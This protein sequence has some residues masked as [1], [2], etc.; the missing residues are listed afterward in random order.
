MLR[1]YGTSEAFVHPT[2]KLT[3]FQ[4]LHPSLI[5]NRRTIVS[6]SIWAF[7]TVGFGTHSCKV[8]NSGNNELILGFNQPDEDRELI[9]RTLDVVVKSSLPRLHKFRPQELN[10]LSWGICRLGH[11]NSDYRELLKGIAQE[12]IK[13]KHQFAPQVRHF[14]LFHLPG[15]FPLCSS[16]PS[17]CKVGVQAYYTICLTCQPLYLF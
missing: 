10:N 12:I 17:S 8:Q 15:A 11:Y 2:G 4:Y 7:A 3:L 1:A 6:N 16:L 9:A 13:R 14:R 5:F